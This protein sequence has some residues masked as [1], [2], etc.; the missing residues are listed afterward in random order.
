MVARFDGLATEGVVGSRPIQ[1]VGRR[2]NQG[3]VWT[4]TTGVQPS[5]S[6][7]YLPD[8]PDGWEATWFQRGTLEPSPLTC[9]GVRVGFQLCT[10]ML[11]T[12]LSWNIGRAGAQIIAAPRATGGHRRWRLAA[13]L[14]GIVS[15]CFVASANRRSYER[16]DFAG[17]SWIVSPE[18]DVLAETTADAPIATVTID[19]QEAM[20]AK[21]TYPRNLPQG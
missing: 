20:A 15:G 21:Q 9:N 8:A 10:E 19:L 17:Q 12:D 16:D 13:S 5:R 2:L 6:K 7:T 1:I 11:F 14:M 4:R 18:G 3:F